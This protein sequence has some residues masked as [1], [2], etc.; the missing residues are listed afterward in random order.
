M[1]D[2]KGSCHTEEDRK[3]FIRAGNL[4]VEDISVEHLCSLDELL[5]CDVNEWSEMSIGLSDDIIATTILKSSERVISH[6]LDFMSSNQAEKIRHIMREL[7]DIPNG[8]IQVSR[9][10]LLGNYD[11]SGERRDWLTIM[12]VRINEFRLSR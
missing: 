7:S 6:V 10:I 11:A 3:E 12:N 9:D 2:K 4:K 1:V 8:Y 5:N